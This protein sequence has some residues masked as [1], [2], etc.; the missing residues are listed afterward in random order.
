MEK[1]IEEGDVVRLNIDNSP[2]MSIEKVTGKVAICIWFDKNQRFNKA[3]FLV[4]D[5]IFLRKKDSKSG[6]GFGKNS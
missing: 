3:E 6:I 4:E 5:L 1:K 2:N